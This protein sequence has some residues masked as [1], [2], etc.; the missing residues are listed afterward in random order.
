MLNTFS[1]KA[2]FLFNVY[3]N[4]DKF[5]NYKVRNNMLKCKC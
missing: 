1:S 5:S 3:L 4:Y 2:D